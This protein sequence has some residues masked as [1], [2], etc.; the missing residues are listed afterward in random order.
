MSSSL[1]LINTIYGDLDIST[2]DEFPMGKRDVKT[3]FISNKDEDKMLSDIK[4]I[5][6]QGKRVLQSFLATS[7]IW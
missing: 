1:L 2:I 6:S 7:S 4:H 5:V 3:V